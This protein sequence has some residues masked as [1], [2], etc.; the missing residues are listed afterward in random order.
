MSLAADAVELPPLGAETGFVT[1]QV[2]VRGQVSLLNLAALFAAVAGEPMRV[3]TRWLLLRVGAHR[4]AAPMAQAGCAAETAPVPNA[5][6]ALAGCGT[7]PTRTMGWWFCVVGTERRGV[8][9]SAAEEVIET[10]EVHLSHA[11]GALSRA[12]SSLLGCCFTRSGRG[13]RR[14]GACRRLPS[15]RRTK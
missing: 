11:A 12:G 14:S 15:R 5:T 4:V 7:S 6:V 10:G 13:C 9:V 3:S 8:R 2:Q 1:G